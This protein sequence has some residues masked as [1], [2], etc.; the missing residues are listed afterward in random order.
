MT[1]I[2]ITGGIG[3]GKSVS[4]LILENLGVPV[5][6]SDVIARE[7]SSPGTEGL[8]DIVREFGPE[9]LQPSG[10]LDRPRL[11]AAVF[12]HPG[13]LLRLEGILHPRIAGVWRSQV[14]AWRDA[15]IERAAVAIPLLF[16]KNYVAEFTGVVC[17]ACTRRTQ[18]RRLRERGWP[19]EQVE[20]RNAAQM[21][22]SEK[23]ARADYVVWTE[24]SLA[25]HRAQWE[26][27]LT[28]LG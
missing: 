8:A 17:L 3:M 2:G 28:A 23:M 6:D 12:P 9:M 11:A 16:E 4:S 10:E 25:T 20:A 21:P 14:N 27:I 19:E 1:L 18:Q 13:A 22:V 7:C 15:G 24:G 26:R 5:A